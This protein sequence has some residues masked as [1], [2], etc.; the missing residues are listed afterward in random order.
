MN[1]QILKEKFQLLHWPQYW[2]QQNISHCF[3]R[4]LRFGVFEH[5]NWLSEL[6]IEVVELHSWKYLHTCEQ[7]GMPHYY[8]FDILEKQRY[9][10]NF[11]IQSC[12][13]HSNV[14]MHICINL[15][16]V[17]MWK[18]INKVYKESNK[19]CKTTFDVHFS[20][21]TNLT[22]CIVAMQISWCTTTSFLL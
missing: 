12:I 8:G 2:S 16:S 9:V 7:Y 18:Q 10:A 4:K 11:T 6:K 20:F 22:F 5:K 14:F 13:I 17:H 3:L 15:L 1:E 21:M 19:H